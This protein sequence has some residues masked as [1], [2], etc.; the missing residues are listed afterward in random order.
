MS[1]PSAREGTGFAFDHGSH[2]QNDGGRATAD[3]SAHRTISHACGGGG[4]QR[5]SRSERDG[6]RWCVGFGRLVVRDR[7]S[8]LRSST[9]DPNGGILC[10][11][12]SPSP[13]CGGRHGGALD[14]RAQGKLGKGGHARR[15][16]RREL[17]TGC[18][19]PRQHRGV[20][21]R[22]TTIPSKQKSRRRSNGAGK[23]SLRPCATSATLPAR[24]SMSVL[25]SLAILT[26]GSR[27]PSL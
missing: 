5:G 7:G 6:D 26:A 8:I 22:P 9:V 12:W 20:T 14:C 4:V 19:S 16:S 1:L 25:T 18:A 15:A 24:N 27:A 23:S 2:R 21:C 17:P 3:H 13:C 10:R 11:F